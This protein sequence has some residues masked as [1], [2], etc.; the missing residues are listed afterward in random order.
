MSKTDQLILDRITCEYPGTRALNAVSIVFAPGETHAITGENGAGKSTLLRVVAGGIRPQSGS[1][2]VRGETYSCIR[3]PWQLGIRIIP[4]EPLL[5]KS[6]S[7]A[8]NVFLGRLPRHRWGFQI[9]WQ[10]VRVRTRELLDR[11]GLP[12]LSPEQ[13]VSGLGLGEQQLVQTARALADGGE[14][15]LFDEPT[16]ALMPHE[17][18]KLSSVIKLL[19][20]AGAIVLFV[21]HRMTEI[22]S[23]CDCVSVL[24]DGNYVGT[25]KIGE[26]TSDELIRMMV[27]REISGKTTHARP[28]GTGVS[29]SLEDFRPDRRLGPINLKVTGGEIV[30]LAGL[31]GAGRTELLESIFGIRAHAGKL[32]V[33]GRAVN[34]RSP[35]EAACAGIA[36]VPED[37][38]RDGLVLAL[39]L[40]DNIALPN[41]SMLSRFSILN[42][43]RKKATTETWISR[44][45]VKSTGRLQPARMLSGGNQQKIVLG[46]WLA[47]KPLIL[48]L[49]EPTRG[50]DVGAKAEIYALIRQ[51]AADG[52]AI[53]LASSE[54]IELFDLCDRILVMR[55]G[56]IGGEVRGSDAD[57]NTILRL[58]AP[59]NLQSL[60][61]TAV[62]Q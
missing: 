58:A 15:F 38:K 59:G 21:S 32:V 53:L 39:N 61:G 25:R 27:G 5:A 18:A 55:E 43:P 17:V 30:G 60:K 41:F 31:V 2:Q 45:G 19:V 29:L 14:I 40:E 28:P 48:L 51:L 52:T 50:I 34:I 11:V 56:Q 9:D 47:R 44:L 7:I 4:Q 33:N 62:V 1:I 12:H 57:E 6:L 3:Q 49:D 24:R 8:E 54:M 16:S 13:P 23:V 22:F 37:R 35:R 46:K 10:T 20:Q 36:L 42:R 26:T